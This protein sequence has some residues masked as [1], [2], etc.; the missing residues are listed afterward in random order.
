MDRA[1]GDEADPV[2][3]LPPKDLA[4]GERD[5]DS[6]DLLR[7]KLSGLHRFIGSMIDSS[8]AVDGPSLDADLDR[9]AEMVEESGRRWV[10]RLL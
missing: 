6:L 8:D 1:L 2:I 4:I 3:N 5:D 7:K 10:A 9:L